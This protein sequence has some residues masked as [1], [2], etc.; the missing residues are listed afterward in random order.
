MRISSSFFGFDEG[1]EAEDIA[2]TGEVVEDTGVE[3]GID[4]GVLGAG[5]GHAIDGS[6]DDGCGRFGIGQSFFG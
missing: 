6:A 4:D 5:V 2:H 1:G 3:S